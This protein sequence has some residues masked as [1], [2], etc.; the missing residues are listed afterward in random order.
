MEKKEKREYLRR[1]ERK[2]GMGNRDPP[3]TA[4]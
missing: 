3:S 4:V 2:L 1:K